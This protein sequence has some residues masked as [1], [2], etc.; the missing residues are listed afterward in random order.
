[1]SSETFKRGDAIAVIHGHGPVMTVIEHHPYRTGL[2][3]EYVNAFWFDKNH[4]LHVGDF[5]VDLIRKAP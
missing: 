4:N 2:T 3:H 5:G 1:M